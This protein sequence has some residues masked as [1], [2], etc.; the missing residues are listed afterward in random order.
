MSK[1][2]L[3]HDSRTEPIEVGVQRAAGCDDTYAMRLGDCA[4]DVA[5]EGFDG[6]EGTCGRE[7]VLRIGEKRCPYAAARVGD[8][9]QVWVDGRTFSF[10]VANK[11][12]GR[13]V[14]AG[15]E[16]ASL[17]ALTA[18]MPGTVLD[19]KVSS[20]D[21]FLAHDALI[22]MESMK[23]ETT[24]SAPA[25]GRVKEVLCAVGDLVQMGATLARLE[26][27]DDDGEVA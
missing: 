15:A 25:A 18:P 14:G 21:T 19:I 4:A 23:M 12:R 3:K 26:A 17:D 9:I 11:S 20:G 1:I 27:T 10:E 7:G 13:G 6:I 24:L 5:V 8:S 2:R 22:V 16:V